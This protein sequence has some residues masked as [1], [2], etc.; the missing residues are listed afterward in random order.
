ML[1]DVWGWKCNA[2]CNDL[3]GFFFKTSDA[4]RRDNLPSEWSSEKT[5]CL[6]RWQQRSKTIYEHVRDYAEVNICYGIMQDPVGWLF[7]P[8]FL[9]EKGMRTNFCM[10]TGMLQLF[11]FVKLMAKNKKKKKMK[12]TFC[13][14]K[15]SSRII[16]ITMCEIPW[17]SDSVIGGLEEANQRLESHKVQSPHHCILSVKIL[18][19]ISF[20]QRTVEIYVIRDRKLSHM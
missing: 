12:V 3:E 5:S 20:T 11:A 18:K 6:I 14:Q 8:Y 1:H 4:Q 10:N 16:S 17:R 7:F 19:K 9:A 13:S 2:K 15:N